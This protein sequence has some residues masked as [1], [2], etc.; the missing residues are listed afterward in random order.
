MDFVLLL[1]IIGSLSL[2]NFSHLAFEVVPMLPV[3]LDLCIDI[4]PFI[5]LTNHSLSVTWL[6]LTWTLVIG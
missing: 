6:E 1:D 5:P 2:Q 3:C 4:S